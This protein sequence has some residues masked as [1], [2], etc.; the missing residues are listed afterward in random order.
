M[1]DN[2]QLIANA[3]V[4]QVAEEYRKALI[5]QHKATKKVEELE[6]FFAGKRIKLLTKLDGPELM[7]AVKDEVVEHNYSLKSIMKSH[8]P[9]GEDS[10]G[11]A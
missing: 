7:Q 10:K 11:E 5:A 8:L 6:A 4:A 2:Y 1:V 3:V 9:K